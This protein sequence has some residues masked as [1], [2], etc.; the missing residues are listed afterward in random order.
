MVKKKSP[1][2]NGKCLCT[3]VSLKIIN[4]DSYMLGVTVAVSLLLSSKRRNDIEAP[5]ALDV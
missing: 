4:V 3:F 2:S 5:K 1:L